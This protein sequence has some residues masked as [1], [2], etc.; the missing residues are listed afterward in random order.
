MTVISRDQYEEFLLKEIRDIPE[1]DLPKLLKLIHFLKENILGAGEKPDS[2]IQA[3]WSSF[4]SWEDERSPED[5]VDE[6]YS[7][8]RST[9]REVSL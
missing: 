5:I 1:S 9:S 4:G 2:D 3:F 7:S 8:R 6:I